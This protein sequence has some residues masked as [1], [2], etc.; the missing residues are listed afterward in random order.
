MPTGVRRINNFFIRFEGDLSE[1]GSYLLHIRM[2]RYIRKH[3][4]FASFA[5]YSLRNIRTKSYTIF[6]AHFLMLANIRS[7]IFVLK[8]IFTKLQA[9]FKFKWI[10]AC[11]YSHTSEYLL[12]IALNYLGILQT[13]PCQRFLA[14]YIN[15]CCKA[16]SIE[17]PSPINAIWEELIE[18]QTL[19]KRS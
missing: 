7:E 16:Q 15:A 17:Y 6:A 1:Y 18:G 4:L 9:K 3:H 19:L 13:M 2:F 10:L 8:R 12:R 14:T 5:S 11:K